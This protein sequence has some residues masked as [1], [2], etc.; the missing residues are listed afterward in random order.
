MAGR[1]SRVTIRLS[2]TPFQTEALPSKPSER[3]LSSSTPSPA[4]SSES[5][6]IFRPTRT[7]T[8]SGSTPS[9]ACP[10]NHPPRPSS[11]KPS[12]L[13]AT[14]NSVSNSHT[15]IPT[16][17][18]SRLHDRHASSTITTSRTD[19]PECQT[20]SHTRRYPTPRQPSR[21]SFG[22]T[23]PSIQKRDQPAADKH[24]LTTATVVTK[25]AMAQTLS[26]PSHQSKL[27]QS[28]AQ[29]HLHRMAPNG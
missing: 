22:L 21:L 13:R 29:P 4:C 23:R 20:P 10:A 1:R 24:V 17:P 7:S 25:F 3:P 9:P 8:S 11:W 18:P 16:G 6:P 15:L 19:R 26:P 12:S 27:V 28:Q 2:D 5:N 14:S